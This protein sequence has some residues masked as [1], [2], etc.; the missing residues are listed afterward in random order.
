MPTA[1]KLILIVFCSKQH[2]VR[3]KYKLLKE[4]QKRKTLCGS[5]ITAVNLNGEWQKQCTEEFF[6]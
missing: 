4:V 6:N 3:Q 5:K 1:T 2:S